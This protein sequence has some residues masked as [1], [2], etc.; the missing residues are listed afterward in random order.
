MY[1][2]SVEKIFNRNKVKIGDR[3]IIKKG[4]QT[5]EG[6]LMPRIELGDRNSVVLKLDN[7]Y[8][9][10]INA[11]GARIKKTRHREP[12]EIKEEVKFE[13]GKEKYKKLEFDRKRPDVSLISTGGTIISKVDYKTG[14][15]KALEKPEEL[16]ANVPELVKILNVKNILTPFNKMSEDF[17]HK[18]WIKLAK[19]CEKELKKNRGVII[20]HGTD[21]MHFTA[22][23]LSFMLKTSKPVILTGS[24]RSSDRGSSDAWM[25]LICSAYASISDIGEVGIVMHGSMDDEFCYFHRGTRVR[26]T[27]STRRDTFQTFRD[28]PLLKIFSNGKIEKLS[29]YRKRENESVK[30]DAKFEPK[31]ALIKTYPESDPDVLNYYLK[32]GYKGFVIEGTGMGHVPT[33]TQKSW[34][35]VIKKIGKSHPIVIV[36]QTL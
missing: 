33:L 35:K 28:K 18:D 22:A 15:V 4:K 3:V 27:H 10:G 17:T 34:I 36:P 20:I 29:S 24:Q 1:S 21:T 25:N 7:G 14:G 5:Y 30:L 16:L 31:V 2:P 8:N 26:K 6:L 11:R 19:M 23:A 32:K 13:M 9:I 12:K